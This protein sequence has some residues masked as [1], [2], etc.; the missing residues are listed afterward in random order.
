[1][2]GETTVRYV[3]PDGYE[4]D[5]YVLELP[6]GEALHE[7]LGGSVLTYRIPQGG[8]LRSQRRSHEGLTGFEY[9]FARPDGSLDRIQN[10]WYYP[11]E[12][13]EERTDGSVVIVPSDKNWFDKNQEPKDDTLGE[14]VV[15]PFSGDSFTTSKGCSVPI[16]H[17]Y[18]GTRA[19][20]LSK[21]RQIDFARYLREH[22]ILN[23]S[24]LNCRWSGSGP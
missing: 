7:T 6:D 21:Y 23:V 24:G 15:W 12:T 5:V 22:P 14:R 18:V 3:V 20:L 13:Y 8:I 4:G 2:V 9:Y 11:G 17:F 16:E 1:M 10:R 19:H